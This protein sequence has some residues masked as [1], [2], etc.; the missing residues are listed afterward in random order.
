MQLFASMPMACYN[1]VFA[2]CLVLAL[3][4]SSTDMSLAARHLLDTPADSNSTPPGPNTID[5]VYILILIMEMIC[6]FLQL[7]A[8]P[9]I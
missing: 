8:L 5:T 6:N 4:L 2:L 9:K 3:L 7:C 1:H